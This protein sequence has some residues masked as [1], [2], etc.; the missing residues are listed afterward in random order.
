LKGLHSVSGDV[1]FKKL[2]AWLEDERG[3]TNLAIR[4][5]SKLVELY[6]LT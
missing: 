3:A 2:Y 4:E 1:V 5:Y 6:S